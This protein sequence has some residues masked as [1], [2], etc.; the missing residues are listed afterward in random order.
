MGSRFLILNGPH[1]AGKTTVRRY[2]ASLGYH[3]EEEVA[4]RLID[5]RDYAWGREGTDQFQ[6]EIFN[7]EVERDQ[8]LLA[9][10][11]N[12]IIETWHFGNIAHA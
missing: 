6:K 1:A 8:N 5:Q 12:A 2:L 7:R 10:N 11:S 4:Q 9:E 3:T